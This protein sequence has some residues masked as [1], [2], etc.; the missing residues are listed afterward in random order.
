MLKDSPAFSGYSVDDQSKAQT[1]YSD[2]L[3]LELKDT[4]MGLEMH[5]VNGHTVFLY[6]KQDHTPADFTVLNFPVDDINAAVDALVE[7]GV[8]FERYDNLPAPVDERGVL[9]GKDAGYGPNIAWFKD[10]AG[11]VL[12]VL[13][14]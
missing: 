9:R 7:K 5:F 3:G 2:I 4:G 14:N 11:N 10:P 8:V 1:F 12:S 13:E 6:P